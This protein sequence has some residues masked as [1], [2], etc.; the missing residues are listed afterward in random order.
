[1]HPKPD[2][3]HGRGLQGGGTGFVVWDTV[4]AGRWLGVT[5]QWP[6][7][8][9]RG[10]TRGRVS[11]CR[12]LDLEFERLRAA[13]HQVSSHGASMLF[14]ESSDISGCIPGLMWSDG[15]G[16]AAFGLVAVNRLRAE[17]GLVT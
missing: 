8:A 10:A 14:S 7:K 13:V 9:A 3:R 11:K 1:M 5:V 15:V 17:A 2:L 6:V 4:A 16:F 12:D